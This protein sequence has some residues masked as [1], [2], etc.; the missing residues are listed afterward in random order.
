MEDDPEY[1]WTDSFRASRISNAEREYLLYRLSGC[2]ARG[3]WQRCYFYYYYCSSSSP[4]FDCPG[5]FCLLSSSS[6]FSLGS[7]S[8]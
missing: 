3:P 4:A 1:H 7:F 5:L 8:C 6:S 2:V